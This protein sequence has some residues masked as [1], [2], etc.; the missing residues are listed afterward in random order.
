MSKID[1]IS[2][3][4]SKPLLGSHRHKGEEYTE[5]PEYLAV[6]N[7]IQK[8][9]R[10]G[11]SSS[12]DWFLVIDNSVKLLTHEAKD[13]QMA[14]YLAYG[15][16]HQYQFQGLLVGLK[17]LLDLVSNLWEEVYPQGREKAKSEFLNWYA[18]Q[19]INYLTELPTGQGNKAY[20]K[21]I[22]K[23]LEQ[24]E[25]ELLARHVAVDYFVSLKNK[26]ELFFTALPVLSE[27]NGL[28]QTSGLALSQ[29]V[30]PPE[31][32]INL[33]SGLLILTQMARDLLHQEP[34]NAYAYYLN[35][36]AS[37]A[38]IADIPLAEAGV[39]FVKAPELFNLQRI[40]NLQDKGL[41]AEIVATAEELIPQEP[42]WLDL[43]FISL[44]ALKALDLPYKAA[45]ETVKRELVHFLNRFPSIELLK[46]SD[47][48]PFLNEQY[49][50][51]CAV[52]TRK[53]IPLVN[54]YM[55]G[56]AEL[57]RK[58]LMQIQE[59]VE[60]LS[61]KK[62]HNKFS[63]LELMKKES[64]SEKVQLLAY[65]A[66]CESFLDDNQSALLKANLTFIVELIDQ[67][68]LVTWEPALALEALVLVYRCMTFLKNT[69]AQQQKDYVFSLITQIDMKVA[70][71][72]STI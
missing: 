4:G 49:R 67:H 32:K 7:E 58:Q 33:E 64:I 2:T 56:L 23:T 71:E 36:I 25:T 11:Q 29:T 27:E 16:F 70:K 24:L 48:T 44:N 57:E 39:S 22:I 10:V 31:S 19:S 3:L 17:C 1:F 69:I 53:T 43:Q 30:P 60:E 12:I 66:I 51:Q 72:L 61:K 35:R 50:E 38:G 13:L 34:S 26:I 47:G 65:M 52:L 41:A 55:V 5:L 21:Q 18:T 45:F 54:K 9:S 63:Q 14:S 20:Q 62:D 42:F 40:K 6:R 8:L 15:L 28:K 68:Q 59:M 37:W 46:F